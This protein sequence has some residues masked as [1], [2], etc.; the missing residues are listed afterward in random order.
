[1]WQV[2]LPGKGL[3]IRTPA[4]L[5]RHLACGVIPGS[6]YTYVD[7]FENIVFSQHLFLL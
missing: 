6:V 4:R 7:I 3:E 1:M 5:H 2:V